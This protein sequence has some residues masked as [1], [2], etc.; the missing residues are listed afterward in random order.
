MSEI[1]Y[2]ARVSDLG[3]A[4]ESSTK[5]FSDD[6][7]ATIEVKPPLQS[8]GPGFYKLVLGR[9]P[10]RIDFEEVVSNDRAT[11]FLAKESACL[12]PVT[13]RV[14]RF[15]VLAARIA[16]MACYADAASLYMFSEVFTER[17]LNTANS[18]Q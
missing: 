6:I 18:K 15:N 9:N 13:T 7:Y 17:Q 1:R 5:Y 3:V 4:L 10:H 16:E 11:Y 14:D 2:D 12:T 8:V